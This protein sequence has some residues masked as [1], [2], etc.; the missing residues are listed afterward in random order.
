MNE[1]INSKLEFPHQLD[2]EPFSSEGL[3]WREEKSQLKKK[4]IE[5]EEKSPESEEIPPLKEKIKA[6]GP[7][8]EKETD[9]YSYKLV[10]VVVHRGTANFGHYYSFI[11]VKRGDPSLFEEN[12]AEKWL[13]FNDSTIKD[14]N[15]L[16]LPAD[17]FG[18]DGKQPDSKNAW[19]YGSG[20]RGTNAYILVYD[21]AFKENLKFVYKTKEEQEYIGGCLGMS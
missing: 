13:G 8:K 14:Y 5:L 4:L 15:Y 18:G 1:K 12:K 11:N 17:C 6:L 10:G 19:A 21:R 2:L 16:N 7:Y 20:A 9:Y 3:E